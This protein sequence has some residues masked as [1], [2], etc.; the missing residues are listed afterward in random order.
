M[1]FDSVYYVVFLILHVYR[2]LAY[3]HT[4]TQ[5]CVCLCARVCVC[6]ICGIACVCLHLCVCVCVRVCPWA[7]HMHV[8]ICVY[9]ITIGMCVCI[10]IQYYTQ[11]YWGMSSG[12]K[13]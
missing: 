7:V 5:F 12:Y 11:R 2:R 9:S 1:T 10:I 13:M 8:C 3:F 6:D 4:S